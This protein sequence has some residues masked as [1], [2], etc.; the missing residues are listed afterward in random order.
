LVSNQIWIV[1]EKDGFQEIQCLEEISQSEI[2]P[3]KLLA[4]HKLLLAQQSIEL[5]Q[6]SIQASAKLSVFFQGFIK[7]ALPISSVYVSDINWV[8]ILQNTQSCIQ[9]HLLISIS[10][11][12]ILSVGSMAKVHTDSITFGNNFVTIK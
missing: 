12:Q 11:Q 9:G 4:A 5:L 10:A 1:I 2:N 8:S 3:N 6:I 7:G